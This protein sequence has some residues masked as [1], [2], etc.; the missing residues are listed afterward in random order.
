MIRRSPDAR[1]ACAEMLARKYFEVVYKAIKKRTLTFDLGIR[2]AGEAG[3]RCSKPPMSSIY[4][5]L[6]YIASRS[7]RQIKRIYNLVKR[8]ILI[9]GVSLRSGGARLRSRS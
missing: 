7:G 8:P 5:A 1:E 4:S 3:M 2:F 6:T 9:G